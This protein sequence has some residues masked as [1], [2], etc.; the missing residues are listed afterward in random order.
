MYAPNTGAGDHI[1]VPPLQPAAPPVEVVSAE[2]RNQSSY[3]E[4]LFE[5]YG[6]AAAPPL[7]VQAVQEAQPSAEEAPTSLIVRDPTQSVRD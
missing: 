3:L 1:S 5:G 4:Q 6:E 2:T 7:Q